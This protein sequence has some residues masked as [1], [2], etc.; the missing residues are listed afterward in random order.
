MN[1][2]GIVFGTNASLNVPAD[3]IAT[4]ATGI[5]F[6][7][8]RW[9]DAFAN[10]DYAILS[11]TPAAFAFDLEQPTPILN[12]AA[13]Q[14]GAGQSLGLLGGAVESSGTLTAGDGLL[15]TAV[16][17]TSRVQ[18]S[19]PGHLLSLEIVPPRDRHGQPL[20]ITAHDLPELLTGTPLGEVSV[21]TANATQIHLVATDNLRLT[22]SQVQA[23]GDLYLRAGG[24][25]Q[26]QDSA[27]RAVQLR[28]GSDLTLQGDRAVDIFA[29]NHAESGLQAGG[30][31][32]LRSGAAIA[33]DAHYWAGGDFRLEH[34]DGRVNDL[35]SPEDPIIF[36]NGNVTI[37]NYS[38]ASLHI[39]AGGSVTT[40]NIEIIGPDLLGTSIQPGNTTLF[41]GS[42]TIGSLA[43]VTLSD[44]TAVTVSGNTQP[45]LDI[46]AGIDWNRFAG[47]APVNGT[48]GVVTPLPSFTLPTSAN[49]ATGNINI[50]A[51]GGLVLLTNRYQ[52]SSAA[53]NIVT[54]NIDTRPTLAL[55]V[56]DNG[57]AIALDSRGSIQ[58]G[59]LQTASRNPLVGQGAPI[60]ILAAENVQLTGTIDTTGA[61]ASGE[62]RIRAANGSLAVNDID[63]RSL[64]T[65]AEVNLRS[66]GNLSTGFIDTSA[67]GSGGAIALQSD[68]GAI[69]AGR[70]DSSG[71][72]GAG[73]ITLQAAAGVNA[74]SLQADGFGGGEIDIATDGLVRIV[75]L[76]A[77][78]NGSTA[79]IFTN[80]GTI[81][82]RHGGNGAIP[83]VI[84]DPNQNG[85]V[86]AIRAGNQAIAPY[87]AYFGNFEQ[88]NI[89]IFT[90]GS[91]DKSQGVNETLFNT[92][93]SLP[94]SAGLEIGRET[95]QVTALAS[96]Q[97]IVEGE[98]VRDVAD[99]LG[100]EVVPEVSL[101][102]ARQRLQIVEAQTGV[103]PA[104]VYAFFRPPDPEATVETSAIWQYP[105]QLSGRR[106]NS[107]VGGGRQPQATDELELVLVTARSGL[108]R[109]PVPGATR[110]IVLNLV[111]SYRRRVTRP[112]GEGY[113]IPA[114][115]LH[116]VLIEPLTPEL[117]SE[118][119]ESL[120]FVLDGGLRSLPLA[121]LYDGEQFL[122][123]RY[124]LGIMPSLSLTDTTY[125]S[126]KNERVL[127]MGSDT[128]PDKIPLPAVPVE[129]ATIT[130]S[131]WP[132][133]A[134]LNDAFTLA[135][136]Q[137]ARR[138]NTFGIV[139]LA[140]HSEFKPGAKGNSYIQFWDRKLSL[141]QLD[142]LQLNQPQVDLLVLSACRTALGDT[143]AEL[144][145][146]GLA[147]LAGV[148]SA[149]GSLWYVS[150]E[151]TLSLMTQFYTDLQRTTTKAEAL[152]RAQVA[153]MRGEVRLENGVLVT[154]DAAVPLPTSVAGLGD[155]DFSH[156]YYWSAFTLI[157]NPW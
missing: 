2:A 132:G 67:L 14:V 62:V 88:G 136:Y 133:Q 135:N 149:L 122:I 107:I 65:A 59:E 4:T 91:A 84:G 40:G 80:S 89:G 153:L 57:G 124:S 18:L 16:P 38:G 131:L 64:G 11:G 105:P 52:P 134:Y 28:A 98:F 71:L 49:I 66:S 51:P 25:V 8:D 113:L 92:V 143:E 82:I 75:G 120:A 69:T 35:Y 12:V 96:E 139:H 146:A 13:L 30:D 41:N 24:T 73:A 22:E 138:E 114:R 9:F 33:G 55:G 141:D 90:E 106:D 48:V 109:Y 125:A 3:F 45:T 116:S 103:R 93:G 70:L 151:G 137:Q 118:G 155:R 156:P 87:Q 20:P 119:I 110:E 111:S 47:S 147:I 127:A 61:L 39:L 95:P 148:R 74:F 53:G 108:S 157:G 129:L 36:A 100:I 145:F 123:E 150:D 142:Q 37:G 32:T 77:L 94:L 44:G 86:G 31:L 152:R 7:G 72:G 128:F 1:P 68:G 34:L 78:P 15:V 79:S 5:G 76:A 63:A 97:M 19:Q 154:A 81:T 6:G 99:Y 46:R 42:E 50:A 21:Y 54:G 43:N 101:A 144:G 58:A 27:E 83:F 17:G 56:N 10:N 23:T 112:S 60:R 140:T 29:L 126:L 117:A 130:G 85:T 121:A 102:E 26:V 115:W 104:L